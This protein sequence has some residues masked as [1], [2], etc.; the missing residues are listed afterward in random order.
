MKWL[1][2]IKDHIGASV[3][4]GPDDF[5]YNQLLM[6]KGGLFSA[7]QAFGDGLNGIMTELNEVLSA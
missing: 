2:I 4:I 6:Q 3:S 1:T 5:E 7:Y